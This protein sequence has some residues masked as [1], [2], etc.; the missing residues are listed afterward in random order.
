MFS[1]TKSVFFSALVISGLVAS[2][3]VS[4]LQN[5]TASVSVEVISDTT[6]TKT[7]PVAVT[8]SVSASA[9]LSWSLLLSAYTASHK[10]AARDTARTALG[11]PLAPTEVTTTVIVAPTET[12]QTVVEDVT[13]IV[14]APTTTQ[15]V[16]TVVVTAS[17][18]TVDVVTVTVPPPEPTVVEVVTVTVEPPETTVEV[19][20][21]TV[22]PKP[23][24]VVTVTVEPPTEEVITVVVEPTQAPVATTTSFFYIQETTTYI[25]SFDVIQGPSFTTTVTAAPIPTA[26][27]IVVRDLPKSGEH[28]PQITRLPALA[29]VVPRAAA[30]ISTDPTLP[31]IL[32]SVMHSAG[33]TEFAMAPRATHAAATPETCHDLKPSATHSPVPQRKLNATHNTTFTAT[34]QQRESEVELTR[35][36]LEDAYHLTPQAT[37]MTNLAGNVRRLSHCKFPGSIEF[38]T[39]LR[40]ELR[41][42]RDTQFPELDDRTVDQHIDRIFICYDSNRLDFCALALQLEL[43]SPLQPLNN[44]TPTEVLFEPSMTKTFIKAE[45]LGQCATPIPSFLVWQCLFTQIALQVGIEPNFSNATSITYPKDMAERVLTCFSSGY[46]SRLCALAFELE[47]ESPLY[48]YTLP[49]TV[50]TNTTTT[51]T[52]TLHERKEHKLTTPLAASEPVDE[53][54]FNSTQVFA[55]HLY[56]LTDC[57]EEHKANVTFCMQVLSPVADGANWQQNGTVELIAKAD[58]LAACFESED[59][60]ECLKAVLVAEPTFQHR[61]D[62]DDVSTKAGAIFDCFEAGYRPKICGLAFMIHPDSLVEDPTDEDTHQSFANTAAA[63]TRQKR[64]EQEVDEAAQ[65]IRGPMPN[66]EDARLFKKCLER[67]RDNFSFCRKALDCFKRTYNPT[68]CFA[69]GTYSA[70]TRW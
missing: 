16:F 21:V 47:H 58:R 50:N 49:E 6:R 20:T 1:Y 9:S 17:E 62:S 32:L 45:A 57:L 38:R 59:D 25:N 10:H 19:V 8:P 37:N 29:P 7:V 60:W 3:P 39:C 66:V 44:T 26:N 41:R 36:F 35:S 43:K 23:T 18:P 53:P 31:E 5:V 22:E 67:Y 70:D 42:E 63:V 65:D 15:D 34:I 68:L 54:E 33:I 24:D 11:S 56:R 27:G 52:S 12:V 2:H 40:Q 55:D 61:I 30:T 28:N 14:D 13:I 51:T 69:N 46:P 4:P 48:Q 64:D